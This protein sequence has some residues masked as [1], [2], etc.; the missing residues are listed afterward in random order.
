M[1]YMEKYKIIE[2]GIINAI[3]TGK[4]KPGE[5]LPGEVELCEKYNVSRVTV[6]KA[7]LNLA[8]AGKVYRRAGDGTYVS[9]KP[10]VNTTG[11]GR[12]YSEDMKQNG[13]IPGS[14]LISFKISKAKTNDFI[15]EKLKLKANESFYE[16]VRLRTGDD[17]PIALSYTYIPFKMMPDFDIDRV[18]LTGSLYAYFKEQY[19]L[20][21]VRKER[22]T[23]AV[24][25][26]KEQKK[27]LKISDEPLL[28]ICHPSYT[29]SGE[30]FEYSETYY[31]GSRFIYTNVDQA[32]ISLG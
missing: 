1:I 8:S 4:I 9:E 18:T 29:T 31:V 5:K 7:I 20:D 30:V 6:R 17:I 15:K 10:F 25:P 21:A 16:I 22:T 14:I 28:K 27:L 24:M 11:Q 26:T 2:T 19:K 32:N 23:S 12:S 3:Q 13:K